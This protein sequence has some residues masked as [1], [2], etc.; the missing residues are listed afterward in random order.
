MRPCPMPLAYWRRELNFSM[1]GRNPRDGK[2]IVYRGNVKSQIAESLKLTNRLIF[3]L[4]D[5]LIPKHETIRAVTVR[6]LAP[7]F[8]F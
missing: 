1:N 8:G 2:Q 4:K 7:P 3:Q 5:S 6:S